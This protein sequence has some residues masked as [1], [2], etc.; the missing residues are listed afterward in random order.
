M[1]TEDYIGSDRSS[2]GELTLALMQ[3][4]KILASVGAALVVWGLV[5]AYTA[6]PAHAA[7]TICV[8]DGACH[9]SLQAAIDAANAG[10]TIEIGAGEDTEAGIVISKNLT[11]RGQSASQ[12]IVQAAASPS[13]ATNRVFVINA[14]V[15][16]TLEDLTVRYGYINGAG[17]G[18]SNNGALT[19]QRVTVS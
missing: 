6:N 3:P 17:G 8:V 13:T 16:A 10:D 15:T 14:G 19:L 9:T 4:V 12:S 18:I 11:I 2:Q 1:P 7:P 5:L